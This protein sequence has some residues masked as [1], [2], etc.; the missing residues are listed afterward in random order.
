VSLAELRKRLHTAVDGEWA[1]PEML[2]AKDQLASVARGAYEQ[3][4]ET[5]ARSNEPITECYKK[6]AK[7]ANIGEKYRE[8][9]GS[10][11]GTGQYTGGAGVTYA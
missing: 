5:C 1:K 2:A 9:W 7:Q 4:L 10:P 3:C 6:C 11:K 8:V